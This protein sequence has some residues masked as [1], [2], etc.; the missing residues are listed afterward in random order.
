MLVASTN[1]LIVYYHD[2]FLKLS[3]HF[4]DSKSQEK[5]T[6]IS[7]TDYAKKLFEE[8]AT[9]KLVNNMTE[10]EL[11]AYQTWTV[12]RLHSYLLT[13]N[14]TNDTNW[15]DNYLRP[16]LKKAMIHIT[17]AVSGLWSRRSGYYELMGLDFTLDDQLN[18]WFIEG[19]TKP[20]MI[21]Y[22]RDR[23]V[24]LSEML[25]DM[26]DI[27]F[28]LLRSRVKRIIH[29]MNEITDQYS[30]ATEALNITE[31]A[32][33]NSKKFEKITRNYFEPEFEPESSNTFQ[34]VINENFKG[35]DKYAGLI[36]E[37]CL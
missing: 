25:A 12:Q 1:P 37:E 4:Y 29:F 32:E 23:V 19:N 11:R 10:A 21:G 9:G 13:V 18:L 33:K 5:G 7:N 36:A 35:V 20:A 22:T 15:L 24:I 2:G 28:G 30:N 26:H 31:I 6:F 3:L 17:R 14:M 34:L 27:I 8:A 16:E